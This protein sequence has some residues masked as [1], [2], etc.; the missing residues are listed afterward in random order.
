MSAI[1]SF[2][3]ILMVKVVGDADWRQRFIVLSNSTLWIYGDDQDPRRTKIHPVRDLAVCR[4]IC[5]GSLLVL[6]IKDIAKLDWFKIKFNTEKQLNAWK[7]RM[8]QVKEAWN[9]ETYFQYLNQKSQLR[10][11][12]EP[13]TRLNRQVPS[14][15]LSKPRMPFS[16]SRSLQEIISWEKLPMIL[17]QVNQETL[18]GVDDLDAILVRVR[19][20]ILENEMAYNR[21]MDKMLVAFKKRALW[22]DYFLMDDKSLIEQTLSKL[23]ESS[24]T[25][26]HD[27][28]DMW[29][30]A[31]MVIE[32]LD[33]LA[34]L[35]I[36]HLKS[37]ARTRM[38][39]YCHLLRDLRPFLRN[40]LESVDDIY[41]D[42]YS[43][44]FYVERAL[45]P[46]F[47][48]Y[49]LKG[50]SKKLAVMLSTVEDANSDGWNRLF[51][52]CQETLTE[53]YGELSRLYGDYY[54]LSVTQLF[55]FSDKHAAFERNGNMSLFEKFELAREVSEICDSVVP[56]IKVVIV[57]GGKRGGCDGDAASDD[58]VAAV[59]VAATGH[60]RSCGAGC[61][62]GVKTAAVTRPRSEACRNPFGAIMDDD[63]DRAAARATVACR[64][65]GKQKT[66]A[67]G[68]CIEL[69][70][71]SRSVNYFHEQLDEPPAVISFAAR[72]TSLR[73]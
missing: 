43:G 39:T 2:C 27:V 49:K 13:L 71:Y 34:D 52:L 60:R 38:I 51:D 66:V 69:K 20:S 25:L 50:I 48:V 56:L 61:W 7:K 26:L 36:N 31:P 53:T 11:P 1:S 23:K 37:V 57:E 5:D 18:C 46:I 21:E 33:D 9:E 65:N 3:D 14:N 17:T 35:L 44:H 59:H 12:Y 22:P 30:D 19:I 45:L 10:C 32:R 8:R 40:N 24:D 64:K 28:E 63:V 68:K 16:R 4:R 72:R 54:A 58:V 70:L 47:R 67:T 62:D 42:V 6:H 55:A 15:K 41:E 29:P 73:A